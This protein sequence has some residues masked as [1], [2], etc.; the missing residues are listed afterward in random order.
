MG[1]KPEN[2]VAQY[3]QWRRRGVGG[4][5]CSTGGEDSGSSGSGKGSDSGQ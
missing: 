2:E 3:Q 5:V 1:K 4:S